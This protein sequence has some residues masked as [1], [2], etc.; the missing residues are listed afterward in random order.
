MLNNYYNT[1]HSYR[2]YINKARW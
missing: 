1:A 2:C